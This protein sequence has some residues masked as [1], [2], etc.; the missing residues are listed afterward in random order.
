MANLYLIKAS[1]Q[2]S[3]SH[4]M[5]HHSSSNEE[6]L[7]PIPPKHTHTD[8]HTPQ[9]T[10]SAHLIRGKQSQ[11]LEWPTETLSLHMSQKMEEFEIHCLPTVA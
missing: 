8:T 7:L 6:R 4:L 3:L 1:C 11:T 5:P 10:S 2:F 9:Y